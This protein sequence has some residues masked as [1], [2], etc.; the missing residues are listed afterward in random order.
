[1]V[2]QKVFE[3]KWKNNLKFMFTLKFYENIE[4]F[5]YDYIVF[6]KLPIFTINYVKSKW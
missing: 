6:F 5:K 2:E 1:M 3:T 4:Y